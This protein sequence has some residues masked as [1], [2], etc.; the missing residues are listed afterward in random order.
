VEET[1]PAALRRMATNL[2]R[3]HRPEAEVWE[4]LTTRLGGAGM[5][6]PA[7]HR[8]IRAWG[9]AD[10]HA[11]RAP[12]QCLEAEA[13]LASCVPL[14][15]FVRHLVRI[16]KF[17]DGTE[18]RQWLLDQVATGDVAR[19]RGRFTGI[20]L[21][22]GILIWATFDERDSRQDPCGRLPKDVATICA[23][24]AL[25]KGAEKGEMIVFR[26]TLPTGVEAHYPTV[27]AAACGRVWSEYWAPA[28]EG[29]PHGW[30]EP[31]PGYADAYACPEVVHRTIDGGSFE[32]PVRRFRR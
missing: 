16:G 10:D 20:G 31:W 29:E 17:G 8:A 2:R 23:C 21:A 6:V 11:L 14:Q 18:A 12:V 7:I 27:M 1:A 19:Q 25:D 32:L 30:T 15:R 9:G 5:D 3:D 26:Y 28:A 4:D 22:G 24:L 13:I